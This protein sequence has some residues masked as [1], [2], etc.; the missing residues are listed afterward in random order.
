MDPEL[1]GLWC[2]LAATAPIQPLAWE[3]PYAEG[4]ALKRQTDRKREREKGKKEV[5]FYC[6][7]QHG[8]NLKMFCEEK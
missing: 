1:L 4:E 7:Q 5:K 8:W 3:F 2:R 6:I